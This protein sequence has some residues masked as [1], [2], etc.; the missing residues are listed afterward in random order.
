MGKEGEDMGSEGKSMQDDLAVLGDR[1]A[2]I[3]SSLDDLT[4]LFRRRLLDDKVKTR[5]LEVL[6]RQADSQRLAPL[7]RE[8]AFLLDRISMI[9]G[10]GMRSVEDEV[11]S[12]LSHYGMER[13]TCDR[14]QFD[15][16]VQRIVGVRHGLGDAQGEVLEVQ[17]EGYLLNGVVLRPQGVIIASDAG[18]G[19]DPERPGSETARSH[20][21]EGDAA[22]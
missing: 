21:A 16:S 2:H 9:E 15:P 4:D 18:Q 14:G 7:C 22:R 1:V 8:F 10:D 20:D 13:I 5:S 17:R 11:L 12:I 19:N 6:T 3:S